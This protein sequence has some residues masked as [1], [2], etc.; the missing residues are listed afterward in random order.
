VTALHGIS[1]AKLADVFDR[2]LRTRAERRTAREAAPDPEVPEHEPMPVSKPMGE[3]G[4]SVRSVDRQ[5]SFVRMFL[6]EAS[7]LP[8]Q[9]RRAGGAHRIIGQ[10]VTFKVMV[11]PG[12]SPVAIAGSARTDHRAPDGRRATQLELAYVSFLRHFITHS[13]ALVSGAGTQTAPPVARNTDSLLSAIQVIGDRRTVARTSSDP[14]AALF[15]SVSPGALSPMVRA[16]ENIGTALGSLEVSF[17]GLRE[18]ETFSDA[19]ATSS[20][21]LF[22]GVRASPGAEPG[23]HQVEILRVARGH[24]IA[25]DQVASGAMGLSGSFRLNGTEVAVEAGDALFDLVAAINLGED[26][27][28]DGQL[29]AGEDTDG[30]F[31]LDGGTRQHGVVASFYGDVLTLRSLNTEAG[32]IQVEDDDGILAAIGLIELDD[33]GE[34]EFRNE[35]SAAGEAAIRVDGTEFRSGTNVFAEAIAGVE[36]EVFGEPGEVL[37]VEVSSDSSGTVGR[38]RAAVDEFNTA[39]RKMNALLDSAGGLLAADPAATRVRAE[40]VKSVLTPVGGQPEDL[41]DSGD[42]GLERAARSRVGISEEQLGAATRRAAADSPFSRVHGV[43]SVYNSLFELG[44]TASDDDT[45]E[46][47]EERFA[48]VLAERPGEVAALFARE[49]EGEAGGLSGGIAV[50]VLDRLDTALGPDG[51]L[52]LRQKAIESVIGLDLG[53][54]FAASVGQTQQARLLAGILPSGTS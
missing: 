36:L 22:L 15:R 13:A 4:A 6:M 25:S 17:A 40:L 54:N 14:L 51:L 7:H 38:V 8:A 23:E 1:S 49:G 24:E 3:S 43:P 42:V 44:I 11:L 19:T 48:E 47:D 41:D 20:S 46:L 45:L 30:D 33:N 32:E 53:R 39:I 2:A 28:G 31:R 27:D 29:D 35:V 10:D 16:L 34:V 52:E 50:R 5:N 9:I 18:R 21:P 37:S 12:G 26:T